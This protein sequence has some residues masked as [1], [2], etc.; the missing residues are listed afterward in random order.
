MSKMMSKY[1]LFKTIN[2]TITAG[3]LMLHFAPAYAFDISE[4]GGAN[5]TLYVSG[6]LLESPCSLEMASS[7][8]D[9][10][11]G[12]TG[13]GQLQR[14]GDEGTPVPF[15]LKLTDCMRT[16]SSSRDIRSGALVW[17]EDQPSVSVSFRSAS[18]IDFPKYIQAKGANGLALKLVN[19][20]GETVRLGEREKPELLAV[21]GNILSYTIT[22][23]RTP[24]QLE[25]G[26][27]RATIDFRLFYD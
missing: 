17:S 14:T 9:I 26:N 23:V 16:S 20:K 13:T 1:S 22:P 3:I 10:W 4:V 8:Q 5:G 6:A 15:Q 25:A 11:L 12:T 7:R 19:D 24:A 21:G 27:Y 2:I 18:D